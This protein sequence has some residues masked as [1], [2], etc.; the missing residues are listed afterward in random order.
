MMTMK[1][2][3]AV[4][5]AFAW[6]AGASPTLAQTTTPFSVYVLGLPAGGTPNLAEKIP[7]L[8]TGAVKTITPYQI[9]STV[10]GD[11]AIAAP[12][13]IVCTKTNGVAFAP[14]ATI[15]TTNAN[16][17]SGGTVNPLRLALTTAFF[18]VGNGSSNPAGVA[19]SGDCTLASTGVVTCSKTGGVAFGPFATQTAPC[20]IAQGC[21]GQITQQA[22]LNA[23]SP[24]PTRAGDIAYY[25]G[26]NWV[27]VAGNNTGIR[28]LQETAAGVP[29][30]V[31]IS[32]T[33]TVTSV[34]CGTGLS[35]GTIT[36][37]G[38]CAVNLTTIT[39]SLGANVALS[40]TASYFDG[41]SIA[42]GATGTWFASGTVTLADSVTAFIYC[43]LWD[44]T[45]VISS[46]T[47]VI[48]NSG[49]YVASVSLSGY[50]ASPAGNLRISCSDASSTGGSILFNYSGNSKDS[51][52]SA[53]RIQ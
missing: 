2:M 37:S 17:I 15:D 9:L 16:N 13:S 35:G 32:G 7:V 29:S 52:I 50:L 31:T 51:T 33:G 46:S 3:R 36:V 40:N 5:L 8:Q 23:I 39:A 48:F 38:T 53:F 25:N 20:S 1:V 28:F 21:T 47:G 22:A 19:M 26:T 30:W 45:T 24:A 43:K 11:C 4:L 12:P 18:Y 42:Q 10:S 49:G 6:L 44:G 34:I 41:P 27:S 14:S